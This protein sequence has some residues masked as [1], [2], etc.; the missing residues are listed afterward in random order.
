[1]RTEEGIERIKK[2]IK[3]REDILKLRCRLK[4]R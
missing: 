1:M 4:Y 3:R 2:L